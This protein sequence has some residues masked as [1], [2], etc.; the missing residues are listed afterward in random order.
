MASDSDKLVELITQRVL[1][2]LQGPGGA[3]GDANGGGSPADQAASHQPGGGAQRPRSIHPPAGVCTG[4]YSKFEE[5]RGTGIGGRPYTAGTGAHHTN[6]GRQGGS[7]GAA[8]S[9][10]RQV[11]AA[12][13]SP[14][15][16]LTG[17]VTARQIEQ[18]GSAV[19]CLS[20]DAR[21]TPLARDYIKERNIRI[22]R[23]RPAGEASAVR[24]TPVSMAHNPPWL[25]WSDDGSIA[26]DRIAGQ[27]GVTLT[28]LP[29]SSDGSALAHAVMELARQ[30]REGR[31]GGGVLLVRSAARAACYANRC[32][33]LRAVVGTC[34]EA[35]E[36]GLT[37]LGANVLILEHPHH[38]SESMR[39]MIERFTTAQRPMIA[40]VDRQ[41]G[42][43]SRCV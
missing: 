8:S 21:L 18:T 37:E 42:E 22:E 29:R 14:S 17:F 7:A 33:S 11:P 28:V 27:T 26:A 15:P 24:G 30:V 25:W 40:E 19:A 36:E 10:P 23:A 12:P 34:G 13:P 41:L 35:V 43:L 16:V 38:G 9:A 2:A 4:D 20:P 39:R 31:A 6:A 1:A 32:P 3:D 5:L